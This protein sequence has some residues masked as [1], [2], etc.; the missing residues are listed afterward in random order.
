[1]TQCSPKCMCQS[2]TIS[3]TVSKSQQVKGMLI[4]NPR[5]YAA[6]LWGGPPSKPQSHLGGWRRK[7]CSSFRPLSYLPSLQHR[8]KDKSCGELPSSKGS[9]W[10]HTH[11]HPLH[12]LIPFR[13]SPYS[14]WAQGNKGSF[15]M[16]LSESYVASGWHLSFLRRPESAGP[17]AGVNPI[18]RSLTR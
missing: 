15:L 2:R 17:A 11:Q 7:K 6:L 1:M 8:C 13:P 4:T 14:P 9:M 3:K 16:V 10:S 12:S 18:S 5:G